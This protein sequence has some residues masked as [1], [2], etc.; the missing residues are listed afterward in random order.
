MHAVDYCIYKLLQHAYIYMHMLFKFDTY[1]IQARHLCYYSSS[2]LTV[3]VGVVEVAVQAGRITDDL[4]APVVVHVQ[5]IQLVGRQVEAGVADFFVS[6]CE[7]GYLLLGVLRDRARDAVG[8]LSTA[9]ADLAQVKVCRKQ[10]KKTAPRVNLE[11]FIIWLEEKNY[12][13]Y[14][15]AHDILETTPLEHLFG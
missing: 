2:R 13:E 1:A 15:E 6:I 8:A 3:A 9:A 10:R 12:F 11:E 4:F 7:I 5:H 14:A